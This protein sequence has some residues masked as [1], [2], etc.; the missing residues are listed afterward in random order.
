MGP[1]LSEELVKYSWKLEEQT[2]ERGEKG[3]RGKMI[4]KEMN[5]ILRNVKTN[6]FKIENVFHQALGLHVSLEDGM[7]NLQPFQDENS[8]V[9]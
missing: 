4:K 9:Q 6:L 1:L 5:G 3:W 2:K 8:N 7:D